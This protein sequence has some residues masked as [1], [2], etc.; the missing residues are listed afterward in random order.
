MRIR[1]KLYATLRQYVPRAAE[2][3]REEGI[4]V[5]NGTTVAAVM[6]M[7]Q[8]PD[9]MRVLSLLN[10]AHCKETTA[11]LKEG[12]LLLFYPLMSGG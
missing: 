9:D 5:D 11:T 1:V 2:I 7:L 3:V 10:G 8:F 6:T 12:D 4:E